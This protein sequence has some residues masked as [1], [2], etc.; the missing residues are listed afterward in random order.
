MASSQEAHTHIQ[1]ALTLTH[2]Q[3]DGGQSFSSSSS[4]TY[5]VHK[6]ERVQLI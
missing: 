6:R 5:L 2:T 3:G 1:E 4:L